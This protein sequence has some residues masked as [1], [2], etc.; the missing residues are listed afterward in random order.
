MKTGMLRRKIWS[1]LRYI[2]IPYVL[3]IILTR[4]IYITFGSHQSECE[5]CLLK[6]CIV[7]MCLLRS[8]QYSCSIFDPNFRI[9][10]YLGER[11]TST[12]I[13]C[14]GSGDRHPSVEMQWQCHAVCKMRIGSA[15]TGLLWLTRSALS[16]NLWLTRSEFLLS[17][18]GVIAMQR[19]KG[20][21]A[22]LLIRITSVVVIHLPMT[23]CNLL[24]LI[25][26][27]S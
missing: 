6:L 2:S 22:C 27:S 8:T 5:P 26:A 12:C 19:A 11:D 21:P 16:V 10:R 20:K 13:F 4:G 1:Q 9:S 7:N 25:K 14:G 24:T 23:H 15:W 17:V 18:K 3:P